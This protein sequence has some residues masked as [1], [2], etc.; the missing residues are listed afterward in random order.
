MAL[1]LIA[2]VIW[3]L[4]GCS[5]KTDSGGGESEGKNLSQ[6]ERVFRRHCVQCHGVEGKGDGPDAVRFNPPPRDF[7]K[8]R[9]NRGDSSAAVRS[10]ILNG[11]PPGMPAQRSLSEKD[12]KAVIAHVRSLVR[13]GALRQ[14]G[15]EPEPKVEP[16]PPLNLT[17]LEGKPLPHPIPPPLVGGGQ[18]GGRGKAVVLYFW[19]SKAQP[20]NGELPDLAQ[21]AENPDLIDVRFLAVCLDEKDATKLQRLT[22]K[23]GNLVYLNP[24]EQARKLY[25]VQAAPMLALIDREGQLIGRAVNLQIQNNPGLI[26]LLKSV[27]EP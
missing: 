9:L 2:I 10:V 14:V 20:A 12:L 16:A 23:A 26:A 22:G 4:H 7:T 6:G 5:G 8:G 24:D 27:S 25:K 13:P 11:I 1:G 3:L 18:G 15:F 19:E 21:L 17:S